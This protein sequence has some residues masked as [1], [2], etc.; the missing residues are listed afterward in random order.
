MC[1][2]SSSEKDASDS[3]VSSGIDRQI[4]HDERRLNSQVK[5]LLLGWQPLKATDRDNLLIR[6]LGAGGS[7]K[8]TILKVCGRIIKTRH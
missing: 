5:L 6:L 4:R 1:T 7:G 2:G 8:S 3:Q